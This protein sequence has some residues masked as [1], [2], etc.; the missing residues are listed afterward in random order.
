MALIG[1]MCRFT[2]FVYRFGER[3][4]N[5]M[6][7]ARY[8]KRLI[9]KLERLLPGVM[10]LKTDPQQRQGILDLLL[11]YGDTWAMLEVKA[12]ADSPVRPNQPYYVAKFNEMSF[13]AFVYPENEAEV[14]D[15][16]QHALQA[17]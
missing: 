8:Q 7:E 2:A 13:A 4:R 3:R 9:D 5:P 10:V 15:A 17:R 12:S 1:G 6:S 16:L 11:L 14:L